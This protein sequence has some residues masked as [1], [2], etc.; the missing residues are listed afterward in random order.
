MNIM[1]FAIYIFII[2]DFELYIV[3]PP[4][5]FYV[6]YSTLPGHGCQVLF[7][8][9]HTQIHNHLCKYLGAHYQFFKNRKLIRPVHMVV[10]PRHSGSENDAVL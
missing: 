5:S 6:W 2:M 9:S 7:V 8:N 1:P 3:V 4:N 10:R